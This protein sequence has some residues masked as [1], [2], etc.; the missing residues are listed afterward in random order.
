M[1]KTRRFVRDRFITR[2]V[3]RERD[4]WGHR[5]DPDKRIHA[6]SRGLLAR[7]AA[8][9]RGEP[10]RAPHPM[11]D[12][13]LA[14]P[15]ALA[16][17]PPRPHRSARWTPR[18][19]RRP[20]CA[21][22]PPRRTTQTAPTP[23]TGRILPLGGCP[24]RRPQPAPCPLVQHRDRGSIEVDMLACPLPARSTL[25]GPGLIHVFPPRLWKTL[26]AVISE[27]PKRHLT[28]CSW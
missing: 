22:P 19:W 18:P 12:D 11:A 24:R 17:A 2:W 20:S 7:G 3:F 14:D 16:P 9:R 10:A 15:S 13:S 6:E 25:L 23:P 4:R 27:L 21:S 5:I 1:S 28:P 8:D 26:G